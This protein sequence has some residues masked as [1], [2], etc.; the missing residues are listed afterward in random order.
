MRRRAYLA[1]VLTGTSAVLA[2]CGSVE[3]RTEHTDPT[4]KVVNERSQDT[5]LFLE[6]HDDGTELATVGVDPS[7]ESVPSGFLM[8][9]SHRRDTRLQSLTQRVTA[10]DGDGA[11]VEL[12]L[13]DSPDDTFGTPPPVSLS[14][15]GTAAVVEVDQFG[16]LADET[17]FITLDVA[18]WP[19]SYHGLAVESTVELVETDSPDH[20]HVLSGR[21]EFDY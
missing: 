21:I 4:L 20:T 2:G 6:F 19:E 5:D 9:I 12:A 7:I 3:S 10:P 8:E 1:S 13:P 14:Q 15:D 18:R 11:S 16:D 17:V